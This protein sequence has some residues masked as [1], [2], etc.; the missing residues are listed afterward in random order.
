VYLDGSDAMMDILRLTCIE[1]GIAFDEDPK[2]IVLKTEG[3]DFK[4]AEHSA[5]K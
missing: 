3:E 1:G 4:I 2:K 5:G